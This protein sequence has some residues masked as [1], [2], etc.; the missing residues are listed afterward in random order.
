MLLQ[1]QLKE[2]FLIDYTQTQAVTR[3]FAQTDVSVRTYKVYMRFCGTKR[4]TWNDFLLEKLRRRL[5]VK[6]KSFSSKLVILSA[7]CCHCASFNGSFSHICEN[8][9]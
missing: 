7:K 8:V 1:M 6:L 4:M 3:S 2:C 5:K 9:F